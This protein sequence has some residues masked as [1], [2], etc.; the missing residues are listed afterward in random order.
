MTTRFTITEAAKYCNCS[1]MAIMARIESGYFSDV[2]IDYDSKVCGPKPL[3]LPAEDVFRY[4]K[5]LK[6]N[7]SWQYKI[8]HSSN[9]EK[10]EYYEKLIERKKAEITKFE[11]VIEELKRGGV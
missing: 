3:T 8:R 10:I 4:S 1:R 9:Q 2:K 6:K 5:H 11:G 7:P